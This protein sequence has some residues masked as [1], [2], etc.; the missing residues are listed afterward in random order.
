MEWF[1]NHHYQVKKFKYLRLERS[2]VEIQWIGRLMNPSY[3]YILLHIRI[4]IPQHE[5]SYI[6]TKQAHLV[7]EIDTQLEEEEGHFH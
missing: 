7:L 6:L 1:M 4:I 3:L 2:C 5:R